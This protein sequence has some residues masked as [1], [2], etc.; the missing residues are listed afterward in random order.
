MAR[1]DSTHLCSIEECS[2]PVRARG[3][4]SLH[5]DRWSRHGDPN[6]GARSWL[7]DGCSVGWCDRPA[8]SR[9]KGGEHYCAMHYLQM[10]SHGKI[11]ERPRD[12]IPG[13]LCSIQG[14]DKHARSPAAEW[15]EMHYSR[16]RKKG[17]PTAMVR[18]S[19]GYDCCQYCGKDSEGKKHCSPRCITRAARGY[20]RYR[21]CDVCHRT[22]EPINGR[23]CCSR[24]CKR[25][26]I[27]QHH[28]VRRMSSLLTP[29]G[30]RARFA[31]LDRDNWVCQ[32]CGEPTDRKV[33]WPHPLYPTID[34]IIPVSKGGKHEESN[35][36]CAHARCNV[37]KQATMPDLY[38][39]K[40]A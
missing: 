36:Q 12:S 28:D 22:Y 34:H 3:W 26:Q 2:R 20:Q 17:S 25:I 19:G 14:C 32:L 33:R 39:L 40:V 30:R 16:N 4:C 29:E 18:Q 13:R 10:H 23:S 6:K 38:A 11:L 24:Q 31:V 27:Q 5:W 8:R 37:R 1:R 15:C 7:T 9:H 35:L 21:Q